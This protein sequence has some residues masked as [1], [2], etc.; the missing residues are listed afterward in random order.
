VFAQ[1]EHIGFEN[2]EAG[3]VWKSVCL[4]AEML[5]CGF[6]FLHIL[7]ISGVPEAS[8]IFFLAFRRDTQFCE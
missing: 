3:K 2:H 7:C 1:D 6:L 5:A 4:R 8:N